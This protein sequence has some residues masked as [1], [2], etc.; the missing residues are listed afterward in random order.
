MISAVIKNQLPVEVQWPSLTVI[1]QASKVS[2]QWWTYFIL[3]F[4]FFSGLLGFHGQLLGI[5]CTVFLTLPRGYTRFQLSY[6]TRH[7]W[8][9]RTDATICH[10]SKLNGHQLH[11]DYSRQLMLADGRTENRSL[12]SS[13]LLSYLSFAVIKWFTIRNGWASTPVYGK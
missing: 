12:I 8:I 6:Q 10:Q 4:Y 5:I 2:L 13:S 11:N 7:D 9:N 3:E 1:S